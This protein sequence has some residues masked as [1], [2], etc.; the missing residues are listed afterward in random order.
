MTNG[1]ISVS[2]FEKAVEIFGFESPVVTAIWNT[3]ERNE[4]NVEEFETIY[5]NH[6][7]YKKYTTNNR[8]D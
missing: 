4:D 2:D 6:M 7:E 5:K 1:C 3:M 8:E